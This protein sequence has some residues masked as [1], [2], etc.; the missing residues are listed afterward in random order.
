[1]NKTNFMHALYGLV[2]QGILYAI[3]KDPFMGAV[4]VTA[5][6]WGREQAQQQYKIAKATGRSVSTMSWKDGGDM[7]KWSRDA[8]LDFLFPTVATFG[9]ALGLLYFGI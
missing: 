6:F 2:I 9:V 7:T 8:V 3:T 4:A 1:M 5:L